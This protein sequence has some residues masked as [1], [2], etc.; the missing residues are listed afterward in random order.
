MNKDLIKYGLIAVG[1]YLV[2]R[3]IQDNGGLDHILGFGTPGAV[4]PGT[5]A[6]AGT[7]PTTTQPAG[8]GSTTP[9][10]NPPVPT[11]KDRVRAAAAAEGSMLNLDQWCWYFGNTAGKPCPDPDVAWPAVD[12]S[13]QI[14]INTFWN[15]VQSSGLGGFAPAY[16]TAYPSWLM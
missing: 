11:L 2:W 6:P 15:L 13:Q 3:Y 4:G 10:T 8:G 1:A 5:H 9:T 16:Q 12:R 7:T 14:D